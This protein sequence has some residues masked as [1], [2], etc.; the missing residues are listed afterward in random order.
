[1]EPAT[2]LSAVA[3]VIGGSVAG[4]IT[5]IVA[6]WM[7][8]RPHEPRGVG[9]FRLQGAIPKNKAR[10][11]RSVGRTVGEKLL[12]AED[13]AVRLSTPAVREA[14]DEAM[15]RAVTAL[16]E[17]DHGSLRAQLGPGAVAAVEAGV[18][19]L[20]LRVADGVAAYAGTAEFDALVADWSARLRTELAG[21]PVGALL[22]PGRR[23]V[24]AEQVEEW[25]RAVTDG[26]GLEATLRRWVADQLR[27]LETDGRPLGD[28]LPE[29]LVAPVEQAI[30]DA[31]PTALD[32]LGDL[33]ADPGVKASIRRALREAFDTA[34]RE[35]LLHERLLARLVVTDKALARLV[36]GF[37]GEGF[38]RLAAA[39]AA[40]DMRARVEAAVRDGLRQLLREPLG[41]RLGRLAPGRREA[42]EDTLAGWLVAAARSDAT[43][44][45]LREALAR[46]LDAAGELTWDRLLGALPPAQA[47][48]LLREAVAGERGRAWIAAAVR[49]AADRLLDRPVGRPAEWLGA[50]D[51][52]RLVRAVGD[53]TWAWVQG[54]I[55]GVVSR[56]Q[57][58]EM[59]EQKILGFPTPVME[60]IIKRVIARELHTIVQ[61][62]WVLGAIVGLM[63][64]GISRLVT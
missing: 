37:E 27:G 35:L 54:Q 28:R 56:L 24:I 36:D 15:A 41:T 4:G 63:T 32:R 10:L 51:R 53:Q 5:N 26:A 60:D 21:R 3:T 18:D 34:G 19:G 50:G 7:L 14:F 29:G 43:R 40:P 1:M 25:V 55:P 9:P 16:L 8:F 11:A 23:E 13:L 39:V 57:V 44:A 45:T 17:R 12:T 61:L 48:A 62:G 6:I 46:L 22:T 59:V 20:A 47:A 49:G 42:L 58:P 64:F 31:L 38:D 30:T 52:E 2:L 33:L